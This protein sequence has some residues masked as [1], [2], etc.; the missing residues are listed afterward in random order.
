MQRIALGFKVITRL[1][2]RDHLVTASIR[3]TGI[4]ACHGVLYSRFAYGIGMLAR[5]LED[6]RL[7]IS[8]LG[9]R[10]KGRPPHP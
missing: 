1:E 8:C 7:E 2:A 10:R 6:G 3:H 4:Q 9:K 5:Y